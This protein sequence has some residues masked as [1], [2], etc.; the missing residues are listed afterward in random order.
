MKHS[1]GESIGRRI[2]LSRGE[3]VKDTSPAIERKLRAMLMKRS[4]EERLKMGCSMH[5]TARVLAVASLL[6]KHPGSR[7]TEIKRL[8]FLHFYGAEFEP[9]QRQRIAA[10]LSKS[11]K[12]S[13]ATWTRAAGANPQVGEHPAGAGRVRSL[14]LLFSPAS[15]R[16]VISQRL[17]GSKRAGVAH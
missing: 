16:Q 1:A 17:L 9:D 6:Q 10:A 13:E 3:Q 8:L 11:A 4:G 5:A 15:C 7:P 2:P 14:L 12:R